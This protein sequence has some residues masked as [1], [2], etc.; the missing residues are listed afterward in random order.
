MKKILFIL[1]FFGIISFVTSF[2]STRMIRPTI[3]EEQE[4]TISAYETQGVIR[5]IDVSQN[6]LLAYRTHSEANKSFLIYLTSDTAF[7]LYDNTPAEL[8]DL[9]I[10]DRL[11]VYGRKT[12]G[13]D[14]YAER[15]VIME[16]E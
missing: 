13:N 14:I 7:K 3:A 5:E 4:R 12:E 16:N 11:V 8:F 15:I 1:L 6:V 2:V 9:R 10:N